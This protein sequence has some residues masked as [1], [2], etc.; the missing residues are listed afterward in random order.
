M[1]KASLE[2]N[3]DSI[4]AFDR[5][6]KDFKKEIIG[7]GL[8]EPLKES[9]SE[10]K[11][12]LK[13]LINN[14]IQKLDVTV[15]S[16]Q[17][18]SEPVEETIKAKAT[19]D[20]VEYL[21]KADINKHN[22]Q[23]NY[24]IVDGSNVLSAQYSSGSEDPLRI[25]LR[26]AIA[27]GETLEEHYNRAIRIFQDSMFAIPNNSGDSDFFINTGEN[28]EDSLK[29]DC[30]TLTGTT[31]VEPKKGMSPARRFKLDKRNKGYATWTLKQD[32]VRQI[33]ENRTKFVN[34]NPVIE[35]I[36]N[37]DMEEASRIIDKLP[38]NDTIKKVKEKVSNIVAGKNLTPDVEN[39]TKIISMINNIKLQ[40][41][42]KPKEVTYRLITTNVVDPQGPNKDFMSE[43]RKMLSLWLA[44]KA[45]IWFKELV[46]STED[47]IKRFES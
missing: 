34:L 26:M 41:I 16:E 15:T 35:S 44:D 17:T 37:G 11:K 6:A 40:K 3:L 43:I 12:E 10:I 30:S 45:D 39:Y 28:L 24:N 8:D 46:K 21:T 25:D 32:F 22:P 23:D 33:R 47:L 13:N 18:T 5:F 36:K 20:I 7:K 19:K 4:K 31:D 9:V 29:I 1:L 42:R 2:V 27:P 38:A 14:R